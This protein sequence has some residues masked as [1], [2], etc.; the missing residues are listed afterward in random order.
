[1][2]AEHVA[3]LNGRFVP[4]AEASLPVLDAGVTTA[5][6]VTSEP[7]PAVVGIAKSGSIG[8]PIL[9]TPTS[10]SCRSRRRSMRR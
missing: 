10:F 8:F 7:V 1:M 2:A 9:S 4:L 6:T 3:W 5:A